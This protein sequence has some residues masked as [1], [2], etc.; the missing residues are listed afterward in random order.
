MSCRD[1]KELL[2]EFSK[3]ARSAK[4]PVRAAAITA[5]T[6]V[7]Q[8]VQDPT[9][10]SVLVSKLRG[11]L[12]GSAEGKLRAVHERAGLVAALQAVAATPLESDAVGG[13]AEDAAAFLATYCK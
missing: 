4:E 3:H 13:T 1:S 5:I 6:A 9:V 7:C 8:K 12:D 2:V 10:F 11:I